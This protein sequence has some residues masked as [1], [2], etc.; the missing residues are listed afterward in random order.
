LVPKEKRW[1]SCGTLRAR[2]F[3][4]NTI[5]ASRLAP[6][7]SKPPSKLFSATGQLCPILALPALGWS[8]YRTG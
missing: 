2:P 1:N 3:R 7:C 4:Y 5:R 8:P 6:S